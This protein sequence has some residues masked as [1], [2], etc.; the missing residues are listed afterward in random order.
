MKQVILSDICN[1]L[2]LK[3]TT[4]IPL[5]VLNV[6]INIDFIMFTQQKRKT[7]DRNRGQTINTN[8]MDTATA[9]C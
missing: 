2:I 6:Y 5:K 7:K 4:A 8:F 1:L 9:I 3:P